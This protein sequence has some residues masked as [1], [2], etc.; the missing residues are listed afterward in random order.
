M[1][2]TVADK[3]VTAD[4][5]DD[6][7]YPVD[8]LPERFDWREKGNY[9]T[10]V[11]NQGQ[12]GSCWAFAANELLES[13]WAIKT[14]SLLTLSPQ[15]VLDCSG[16]GSCGGGYITGALQWFKTNKVTETKNYAYTAR[17]GFCQ[18]D[19]TN[20]PAKTGKLTS[21]SQVAASNGPANMKQAIMS[22]SPA[23]FGIWG[24]MRVLQYYQ[25][26]VIADCGTEENGGHAMVV[27]GWMVYNGKPCWRVRNS[28]GT[29][30]GR[31][32]YM[33]FDNTQN[34]CGINNYAFVAKA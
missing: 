4:M 14:K 13:A 1:N 27:T 31:N 17:D 11:K 23:V 21:F 15:M 5:E 2:V 18:F 22:T 16:A 29:G 26:G 10:A 25:G 7:E 12:C 30:F 9:V 3:P 6:D 20:V 19:N 33:L 8:A 32:G 28:W 34:A 24:D